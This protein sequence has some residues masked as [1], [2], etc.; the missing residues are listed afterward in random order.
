[1]RAAIPNPPKLPALQ[2]GIDIGGTF[3]DFSLIDLESGDVHFHKR[4]STPRSPS[5]AVAAGLTELMQQIGRGTGEITSFVHG[6]TIGLNAVLER[7]G[8]RVALLVSKGNRDILEIARLAR[9]EKLTIRARQ[10]QPLVPRCDVYEIPGRIAAD[11][12]VVEPLTAEDIVPVIT[13]SKKGSTAYAVCLLNAHANAQHERTVHEALSRDLEAAP[14]SRSS[15]LWP[16]IREYERATVAVLNAY[17][18][19]IMTSYIDRLLEEVRAAGLSTR[20]YISQSNGGVMSVESARAKPVNTLL[21]GPASGV[22]GA[23]FIAGMAGVGDAVTVDIGGTSADVSLIREG[24]PAHS[25][26]AFIGDLPLVM[27]TVDVFSVGAGGGSIAW[28]DDFG[29]L[30]VGPHSA[31]ADPGPACYGLGGTKPTVTDAYVVCGYINPDNFLGGKMR[32]ERACAE[33]AI[34]KLAGPL[35][36]SVEE[37]ARNILDIAT[38][39]MSTALLPLMTKRG[40]DPQEFTLV[41]FGGAGATHACLLAEDIGVSKILVPPSP[42]TICALGAAISDAKANYIRSIRAP[43]D[44]LDFDAIRTHFAALEDEARRW[45]DEDCP[46]VEEVVLGRSA[47]MRYCGQAFTIEVEL[48]HPGEGLDAASIASLFHQRYHELYHGSHPDTPIEL[49]SLRVRVRGRREVVRLR[50][51][52]VAPP[53][54]TPTRRAR[55]HILYGQGTHL[56]EVYERSDLLAGHTVFGPAL[57]E[58]LDTTTVVGPGRRVEVDRYGILTISRADAGAGDAKI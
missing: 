19:P 11:G 25:T 7:R 53:G 5:A 24:E 33:A 20:V 31:G 46:A 26:E 9:K 17:V 32:L 41:P 27:P 43:V 48:P 22:V 30:K 55:R 52:P 37:A 51:I 16:E 50:E 36:L 3:T 54:S 28:V 15:E 10:P 56:A 14:C 44:A 8:A 12:I 2:L 35:G 34:A 47:D 23:A 21:S 40:V 39:T 38:N 13:A 42:G 29:L 1:M 57:I 6:T 58:Q 45:I 4:P 18:Q 49:I